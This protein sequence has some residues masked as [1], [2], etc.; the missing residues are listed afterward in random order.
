MPELPE[1]ETIRRDLEPLLRGLAIRRLTI[2]KSRLARRHGSAKAVETAVAGC[3][4]ERLERRGKFLLLRLGQRTLVI[5][6]GMTG[7]LLY[8]PPD[9]RATP[10]SH[11]HV[12][13]EFATGESL[14]LRDVRQFGEVYVVEDSGFRPPLGPEPL[15]DDFSAEELARRLQSRSPVK[16]ALLDQRRIAG[17]GN[18]YA[19]ESLHRAGIHPLRTAAALQPAEVRRLYSAIRGVLLEAIEHRGSSINDYRD[20]FGKGGSMQHRHRVYGRLD[21]LCSVCG[22]AVERVKVAGRSSYYCPGCQLPPSGEE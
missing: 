19:D 2:L 15:A 17:L 14:L 5:H 4:I 21:E 18:I 22:T 3:T 8:L 10:D 20:G 11:I 13:I 16:A 6:L 7:Q 9:K 1:V 12:V